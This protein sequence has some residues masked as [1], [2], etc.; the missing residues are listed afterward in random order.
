MR[1]L[2]L[3][4][5]G[6][7]VIVPLL[8]LMPPR[9]WPFQMKSHLFREGRPIRSL[10]LPLFRIIL[11]ELCLF[12]HRFCVHQKRPGIDNRLAFEVQEQLF[13]AH[14]ENIWQILKIGRRNGIWK[15]EKDEPP[16]LPLNHDP[17]F[18]RADM[19]FFIQ[20]FNRNTSCGSFVLFYEVLQVI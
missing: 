17:I 13:S 8:Y 2:S 16:L 18:M 10:P 19:L 5:V 9:C 3:S 14:S 15:K 6:L 12:G 7:I 1:N 11:D 20:S 4:S